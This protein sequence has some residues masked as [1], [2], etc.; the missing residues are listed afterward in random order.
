[1]RRRQ[2]RL[3]LRGLGI[4][5][6]AAF[7]GFILAGCFSSTVSN[8]V[9]GPAPSLVETTTG[10][11]ALIQWVPSG[12]HLNGTY[13]RVAAEYSGGNY[14]IAQTHC[15]VQGVENGTAITVTLT[16]CTDASADGSYSGRLHGSELTLD[17]P[18]SSGAVVSA[19]FA[20]AQIRAY[21]VAVASTQLLAKQGNALNSYL[22]NLPPSNPCGQANPSP[23]F[24]T[25]E[26]T[27][28]IVFRNTNTVC[29]N[30]ANRAEFDILKWYGSN[31]FWLPIKTLRYNEVGSPDSYVS[32]DLGSHVVAFA[33]KEQTMLGQAYQ[34][35]ADIE[36][37]W[38]FI[39]FDAPGVSSNYHANDFAYGATTITRA[40]TVVVHDQICGQTS[41]TTT[42][43]NLHYDSA[44][45]AFV[46]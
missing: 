19:T 31:D 46:P 27:E 10:G 6:A 17:V 26:G 18:T 42:T 4:V 33:V 8:G 21:N 43:S 41:C 11:A 29:S 2:L 32:I 16:S 5:A 9:K 44:R 12:N 38:K 23:V 37:H 7:A 20:P 1:M 25:P 45:K 24:R 39:P 35:I 15:G 3:E 34:V 13:D 36:D 40:L 30:T 22:L 28:I 14:S